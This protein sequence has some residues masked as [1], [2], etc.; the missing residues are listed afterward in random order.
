MLSSGE[1]WTTDMARIVHLPSQSA[2]TDPTAHHRGRVVRKSVHTTSFEASHQAG[3]HP[4]LVLPTYVAGLRGNDRVDAGGYTSVMISQK[5]DA[6]D[7]RGFDGPDGAAV[8]RSEWPVRIGR[9]GQPEPRPDYS[10]LTPSQ[11][12]ALCWEITKQAWAITGAEFD[13]SAFCRDS[14]SLSRGRR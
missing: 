10:H 14:V 8:D 9:V 12:I 3:S 5:G 2:A 6:P 4:G 1:R 11:R 13:E 7:H